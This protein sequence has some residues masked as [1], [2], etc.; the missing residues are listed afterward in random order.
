MV[1]MI[2]DETTTGTTEGKTTGMSTMTAM[3]DG[4]RGI[5]R[6][7]H[8]TRSQSRLKKELKEFR[9]MIQRIL[10]VPKPL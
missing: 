1:D 6:Q 4:D 9:E 5:G 2:K 3:K 7:G 8:M 10:G